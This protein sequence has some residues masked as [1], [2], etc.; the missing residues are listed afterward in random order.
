MSEMVSAEEAR[1]TMASAEEET[2]RG[3]EYSE[4]RNEDVRAHA[5]TVVALHAII[6]GR[7]EPPTDAEAAAH[8]ATGGWWR[9][10]RHEYESELSGQ[11]FMVSAQSRDYPSDH[12]VAV[13]R[14]QFASDGCVATWW[15][16]D[17]HGR[18]CA[19][20]VVTP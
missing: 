7:T 20:P 12:F 18:P 1:E 6:E 11:R 5:R 14:V 8:F 9:S 16:L 2:A 13:D 19:W 10:L 15:P 17:A 3:R 4:W